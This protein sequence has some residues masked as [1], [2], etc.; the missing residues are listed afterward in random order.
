MLLCF[1]FI[2]VFVGGCGCFYFYIMEV[3][4]S[5][6]GVRNSTLGET[7]Q[8][9]LKRLLILLKGMKISC[10]RGLPQGGVTR[11]DV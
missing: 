10:L 9:K 4:G 8:S 7:V 2:I 11:C 5:R 6:T 1:V 3:K